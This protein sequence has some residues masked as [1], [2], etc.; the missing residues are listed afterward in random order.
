M[1]SWILVPKLGMEG[2]AWATLGANFAIFAITFYLSQKYFYM[3]YEFRRIAKASIAILIVF[4]GFL[5]VNH[6]ISSFVYAV[7]AKIILGGFYFL[8]LYFLDF[9]N[10]DEMAWLVKIYKS[11]QNKR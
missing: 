11:T 5:L 8:L 10:K 3:P 7:L 6:Y 4:I 2:A 1:F 9:L